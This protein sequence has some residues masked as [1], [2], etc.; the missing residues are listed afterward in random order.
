MVDWEDDFSAYF[1]NRG[2]TMRRTAYAL[3]GDWHQAEDLVQATFVRLYRR[4]RHLRAESLDAYAYRVMVNVFLSGRRRAG[5][6]RLVAAPPDRVTA[7]G[8]SEDRIDLGRALSGLPRQQRATVV[9]RYL[10]DLSVAEVAAV[11]GV[12]EGTVKSQTARGVQGLRS[13]LNPTNVAEGR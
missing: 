1:V 8:G 4:W 10:V 11:M 12:A 13:A 7:G 2:A 3:C 6:E 5:R 9:L